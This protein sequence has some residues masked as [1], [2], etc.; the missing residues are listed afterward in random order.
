MSEL[1]DDNRELAPL[2]IIRN[3]TAVSRYPLHKLSKGTEN[4]TIEITRMN[5]LG[6]VSFKW[7]VS[8]NNKYGQPGPLAYKIDTLVINRR[9]EEAERPVPKNIR[10]G[11]LR[12]IASELG[13]GGDTSLVKKALYQNASAFITAKIRYVTKEK[14]ERTAEFGKTRYG[15]LFA[16]EEL[17]DGTT[18]DAVYIELNDWYRDIINTAKTRPL[19]YDYLRELPPTAPL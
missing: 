17:A 16:G 8:Y 9:I 2:N 12:E 19:D 5:E 7:D 4:F 6:E 15:V 10:L 14:R 13:L 11:S 3:E 1:T 18:A